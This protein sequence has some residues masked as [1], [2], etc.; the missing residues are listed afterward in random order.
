[1]VCPPTPRKMNARGWREGSASEVPG[2]VHHGRRD[3]VRVE[4]PRAGVPPVLHSPFGDDAVQPDL[5]TVGRREERV[6]VVGVVVDVEHLAPVRHTEPLRVC[7][8]LALGEQVGHHLD[9]LVAQA[10]AG[11]SNELKD[12]VVLPLTGL[13]LELDHDASAVVCVPGARPPAENPVRVLR[14]GRTGRLL[15][16]GG[17]GAAALDIQF[18]KSVLSQVAGVGNPSTIPQNS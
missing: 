11:R 3:V 15:G 7:V 12:Q 9:G 10:G 17:D 13:V 1:M 14:G 18:L 16:R 5:E 2:C 4:V 8:V 6:L